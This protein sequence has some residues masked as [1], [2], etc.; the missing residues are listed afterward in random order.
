MDVTS[1]TRIAGL[2]GEAGR[3]QMLAALLGSNGHSASALAMAAAGST[4]TARLHLLQ[5]LARRLGTHPHANVGGGAGPPFLSALIELTGWLARGGPGPPLL[6][7]AEER[8]FGGGFRSGVAA[9][10][11]AGCFFPPRL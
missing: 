5:T 3:I 11:P 1:I 7:L 2:I 8:G 6:P 9:P 4:P 10:R